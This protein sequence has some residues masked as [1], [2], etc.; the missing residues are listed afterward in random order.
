VLHAHPHVHER[1]HP[2][3]ATGHAHAHAERLGRSPLA[4]FGIGMVHGLGGSAGTGI[5][6]VGA[7]AGTVPG[8]A[9]LVLFAGGTAASMAMVSAAFGYALARPP[10]AT[11]VNSFV[12]LLAVASLVFGA[13]YA[14]TA[15]RGPALGV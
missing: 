2:E 4:A 8:I 10:V 5:L 1:S 12:P 13:W 3:H 9:A 11:R 15:I 6:V 7:A 14:L